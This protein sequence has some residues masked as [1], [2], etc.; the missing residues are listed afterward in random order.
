VVQ[1]FRSRFGQAITIIVGLLMAG[2]LVSIGFTD[3]LDQAIRS[4]PALTLVVLI[5][6]SLYWRPRV[7]ADDGGVRIINVLRTLGLPSN[8]STPNTR[9]PSR[10]SARNTLL[11]E[12]QLLVATALS[13]LAVTKVPTCL[14]P[15]TL[16]AP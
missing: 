12:P 9:S 2:A 14:K 4:L 16:L 10:H 8:S 15:L 11:G 6:F 3:G 13:L 7:E 5:V 1:V